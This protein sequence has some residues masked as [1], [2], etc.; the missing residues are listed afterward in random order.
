MAQVTVTRVT[1]TRDSDSPSP[2]ALRGADSVLSDSAHS[3]P[4]S[5][6]GD[7]AAP[8][9][10]DPRPA[11]SPGGARVRCPEP[12]GPHCSRPTRSPTL[13]GSS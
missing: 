11:R 2:P 3:R 10:C 8:G 7:A 1:V 5:A 4:H 9:Q 12:G 6:G 13:A